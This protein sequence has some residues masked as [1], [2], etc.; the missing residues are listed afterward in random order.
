MARLDKVKWD[1]VTELLSHVI[2]H[3]AS[4]RPKWRRR[5][6]E[7]VAANLRLIVMQRRQ[8]NSLG[9]IDLVRAGYGIFNPAAS[10]VESIAT[11]CVVLRRFSRREAAKLLVHG[12]LSE[13]LLRFYGGLKVQLLAQIGELRQ[14][15]LWYLIVCL[16]LVEFLS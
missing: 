10:H 11:V 6:D 1:R 3:E 16:L 4:L 15:I 5:L 12:W 2:A 7:R 9:R 8:K 13:E 14:D